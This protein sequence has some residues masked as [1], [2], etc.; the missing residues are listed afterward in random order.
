MLAVFRDDW[1]LLWQKYQE[2]E[3]ES[4]ESGQKKGAWVSA[5]D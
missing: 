4:V 1:F 5:M 3:R 2:V